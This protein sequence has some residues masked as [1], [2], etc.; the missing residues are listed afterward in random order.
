MLLIRK[1]NICSESEGNRRVEIE[2]VGGSENRSYFR[3]SVPKT[4]GT[5]TEGCRWESRQTLAQA[6]A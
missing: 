3:P 4:D 5:E 1:V 6:T 2:A